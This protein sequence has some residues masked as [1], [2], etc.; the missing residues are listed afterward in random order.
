V[1]QA[2]IDLDGLALHIAIVNGLANTQSLVDSIL[3][4]EAQQY[5]FIE[6][7]C[8]PNG[9][10]GGGGQPLSEDENVIVKRM[11]AIYAIDER[12]TIRKSHENP[13]IQKLYKQF[14][15]RPLSHKSHELLH[16]TYGN[17]VRQKKLGAGVGGSGEAGGLLILF[18]SQ[19]GSTAQ[20]ARDVGSDAKKAG[21]VVRVMPLDQFDPTK[22]AEESNLMIITSTYGEGE[23]PD[24]A[25]KFANALNGMKGADTLANLKFG[26]C[27]F[28][29]TAYSKFCLAAKDLDKRI[30]E[31]GAQPITDL[32]T[33]DV[34]AAGGGEEN[35]TILSKSALRHGRRDRVFE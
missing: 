4:G 21:L 18:G 24:N 32:T 29:S 13:S 2:T 19:G 34:K 9:C 10:I 8:C 14:L 16:T 1:K 3:K 27:G 33:C 15:E 11:E 6:V 30:R 31:L 26:V 7:M 23:M 22:L 35:W 25:K 5:H 28:G 17:R 20:K 12:M